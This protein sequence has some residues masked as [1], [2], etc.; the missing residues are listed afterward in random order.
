MTCP[1]APQQ[2]VRA[3]ECRGS[4]DLLS[5]AEGL[6][7]IAWAAVIVLLI[8]LVLNSLVPAVAVMTVDLF[9]GRP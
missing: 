5:L 9:W 4:R 8:G 7:M 1:R 6:A 3:S 2:E